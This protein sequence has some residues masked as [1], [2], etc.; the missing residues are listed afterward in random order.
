M[1]EISASEIRAITATM[2]R[3]RQRPR[4]RDGRA[5]GL[6]ELPASA[7][8][9]IVGDLHS[10]VENLKL[11]VA[12]KGNA[13]RIRS[14]GGVLVLLGDLVH[15]DQTGHLRE[16]ESSIET[17]EYAFELFARFRN[18]LVHLRG[19]HDSFDERLVKSGIRQGRELYEC[20][21]RKRGPEYAAAVDEY[22][23]SLPVCVVGEGYVIVHAGPVRGGATRDE[24][25]NIYADPDRYWQI[26]WNRINEFGGTT[27]SKEYDGSD[28]RA[29]LKKLGMGAGSQF[30]VGHNP[31]WNTGDRTGV[32]MDVLG[33][34]GHHILYS[35][36]GTRAPYLT[37][38]HGQVAVN[39]ATTETPEVL[40][41]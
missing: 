16:M 3:N 23:T 20:V 7:H 32:W 37:V 41:V 30:I 35:G 29:S 39:F 24:L 18:R 21:V 25:T 8:P 38:E 26:L 22:F 17:L 31:L 33:I 6:I 15:N 36:R 34:Q 28:V 27:T 14:G 4:D 9:I 40:Y 5:G 13:K 19:N 11:I 10:C 2:K 12:D 1:A